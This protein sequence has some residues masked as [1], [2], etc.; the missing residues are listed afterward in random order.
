[1][2]RKLSWRI[3]QSILDDARRQG[4]EVVSV[5]GFD[6]P[7]IDPF[8][9]IEAEPDIYAEGADL[10]DAFDGRLKYVGPR[11]LLTFNTKYNRWHHSGEHHPKVRF[12]IGHE[13][14]HYFLDEHR[15]YLLQGGE[16]HLC[17]TEFQ[18]APYVEQQADC[19]SAG[20]LMPT[21]LLSPLINQETEPNFQIIKETAHKFDVS[22]TSMVVRWAQLSD[23][24]CAAIAVSSKGI[25]WGWVSE[26]FKRIKGYRVR[27]N[28][29]IISEDAR[30]FMQQDKSFLHYR[31]GLGLGM[32]HQ[33][34]EF[35]ITDINVREFYAI[36][37]YM[38]RM[39][40][41]IS[42]E[43]DEVYEKQ[44]NDY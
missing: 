15:E 10:Q 41:F 22:I 3:V 25:D 14:G 39:L 16:A 31:E 38:R 17:F 37:P 40:V 5:M 27:R 1:M 20:L 19:F 18:S 8:K 2:S 11:F 43:E 9:I 28:K 44:K 7:P 33:W 29:A 32:E 4:E 6:L 36:I 12:T 26:G 23:F 30:K 21:E 35:D 42:G 13:L 34:I 24:P